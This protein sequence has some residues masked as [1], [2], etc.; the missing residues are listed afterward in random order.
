VDGIVLAGGSAFGLEASS[1]VRR[2]LA[3]KGV[4]VETPAAKIPLVVSGILYD[5]SIGK[6]TE[7]PSR[8]MGEAAAAGKGA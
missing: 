2:F 5:L 3:Q 4:G 1:G 6:S 7:H 8:E